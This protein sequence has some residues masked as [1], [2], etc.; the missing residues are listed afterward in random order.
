MKRILLL[1]T[2]LQIGGTPT[3][4]R[5]LALR[6]HDPPSTVV[7]VAC[8]SRWGPVADQLRAAG[9]DVTA[10]GAQGVWELPSVAARLVRLIHDR[11]IGTVFS[12]LLHA[13]AVAAIAKLFCPDVRFLQ[14]IQTTQPWPRWHWFLQGIVQHAAEAIVVPS[15][16]VADAA[17]EWS[18][19]ARSRI[20][21][22]PNAVDVEE[23][24]Q[25]ASGWAEHRRDVGAASEHR[26]DA[27]ATSAHRQDACAT[28][29][30]VGR[31]DLRGGT[32]ARGSSGHLRRRR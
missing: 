18:G 22:I 10:L 14:S 4:V 25:E 13:N 28:V 23:E 9:I 24:G 12:F 27:G 31:L 19:I 1:N 5:E 32:V 29:G 26:Q 8:L 16:S 11:G 15:P 30:F 21:V 3:V 6:L 17:H 20:R 7:D 2:D